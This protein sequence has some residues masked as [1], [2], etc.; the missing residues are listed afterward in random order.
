MVLRSWGVVIATLTEVGVP[1]IIAASPWFGNAA[2]RPMTRP[3]SALDAHE[4]STRH[5]PSCACLL[6][7][8]CFLRPYRIDVQQGNYIDRAE[9]SK[10]KPD[11]TRAQVRFILGTPLIADPFNPNRWDYLYYNRPSGRI[12]DV[13]RL[14]LYF[15]GDRL[16]RAFADA[17]VAPLPGERAAAAA[18]AAPSVEPTPSADRPRRSHK[19]RRPHR[20]H[21]STPEHRSRSAPSRSPV[22]PGRG[23]GSDRSDEPAAHRHRGQRRPHGPRPARGGIPVPRSAPARRPGAR[24]QP[25]SR[26]GRGRAARIALRGQDHRATCRQ[27]CPARMRWWTSPVPKARCAI[28]RSARRWA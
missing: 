21:R 25:L 7:S 4:L 11:M 9:I 6:L 19:S 22:P 20:S 14:T 24:R 13:R 12:K 15:E 27:R 16:K 26:Q 2:R 23:R 17:A 1:G 8:G 10:L 3:R 28:W 5:L 18:A